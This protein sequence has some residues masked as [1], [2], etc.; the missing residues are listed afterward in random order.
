[1]RSRAVR[2]L[3]LFYVMLWI[4]GVVTYSISTSIPPADGWTASTFLWVAALISLLSSCRIE[5]LMLVATS[6]LAFVLE[7]AGVASG[8]IF[9]SYQYT[10]ALGFSAFDVPPAISA[11]WIILLAYVWHAI[12]QLKLG[13]FSGAIAGAAWM[14]SIDLLIDP[15][16]AGPL[17]YWHWLDGGVFYGI[18]LSNFA[19]WFGISLVLLGLLNRR[20]LQ[21]AGAKRIGLSVILFFTYIAIVNALWVPA[22]IGS[23]LIIID[24]RLSVAEW[25]QMATEASSLITSLK[26]SALKHEH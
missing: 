6:A 5:A 17:A 4:G 20:P 25:R 9:G 10:G 3:A 19:G 2:A 1:M 26:G 12:S 14:T 15:L 13:R 7:V 23:S 11:A 18:P 22:F 21:S 8:V 24:L 16:A